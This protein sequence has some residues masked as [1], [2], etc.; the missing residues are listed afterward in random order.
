MKPL[1]ALISSLIVGKQNKIH[2]YNVRG[3]H[4][5]TGKSFKLC[6]SLAFSSEP[7]L[8]SNSR[9]SRATHALQ[10]CGCETGGV[11]FVLLTL[12]A[13]E[14]IPTTSADWCVLTCLFQGKN[15]LEHRDLGIRDWGINSHMSAFG[16]INSENL[17]Y[18]DFIR[19][20]IIDSSVRLGLI[21][22][23][24]TTKYLY[25]SA[26]ADITKHQKLNFGVCLFKIKIW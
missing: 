9:A 19:Y 23:P 7:E 17:K 13:S 2:F 18:F 8:D 6:A 12:S 4:C 1:W 15:L 25:Y 3:W 14:S 21:Q 11:H 20:V 22:E 16:L 10:S 26:W 24:I 5:W